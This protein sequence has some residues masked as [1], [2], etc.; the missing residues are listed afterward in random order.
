MK[1][2][3]AR[4]EETFRPA[5]PFDPLYLFLPLFRWQG[6]LQRCSKLVHE[7]HLASSSRL[8]ACISSRGPPQLSPALLLFTFH[9]RDSPSVSAPSAVPPE[10]LGPGP[11]PYQRN[12]E[13]SAAS[14][15][16]VEIRGPGVSLPAPC[17]LDLLGSIQ[18]LDNTIERCL[19]E[20]KKRS[21]RSSESRRESFRREEDLRPPPGLLSFFFIFLN[22]RRINASRFARRQTSRTELDST[23]IPRPSCSCCEQLAFLLFSRQLPPRLDLLATNQHP[24]A[25]LSNPAPL[26][27]SRQ[28]SCPW[29][30]TEPRLQDL[31]QMRRREGWALANFQT[32]TAR[33]T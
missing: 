13:K 21:L 24:P 20:K 5:R 19:M 11:P 12:A 27:P 33:P 10:L 7:N 26:P 16:G 30:Q 8:R 25:T 22:P 14:L 18:L 4:A 6:D 2:A 1:T 31:G 23:P 9:S 29:R 17:G 28:L 15:F 3:A 32:G